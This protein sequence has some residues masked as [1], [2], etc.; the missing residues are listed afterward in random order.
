M[1]KISCLL[2]GG[3]ILSLAAC[4]TAPEFEESVQARRKYQ[5]AFNCDLESS[6]QNAGFRKCVEAYTD[7]KD[8]EN[9]KV[10]IVEGKDGQALVIPKACGDDKMMEKNRVYPVV[11]INDK[12]M[13]VEEGKG[14]QEEIKTETPET[15]VVE[16][17]AIEPVA[18]DTNAD[19]VVEAIVEEIEVLPEDTKKI[20][21]DEKE[22]L[23]LEEK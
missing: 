1:K 6:Y 21:E 11:D 12:T 8:K 2:I 17:E 13:K 3:A 5:T 23:P 10:H 7:R 20:A 9:R 4:Y 14:P 19:V 16:S 15:P 18:D 22:V